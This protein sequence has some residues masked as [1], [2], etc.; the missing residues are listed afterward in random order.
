MINPHKKYQIRSLSKDIFQGM[1]TYE[2]SL[3]LEIAAE[4]AVRAAKTILRVLDEQ[5]GPELEDAPNSSYNDDD[6][7]N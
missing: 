2:P 1:I 3:D 7:D 4:K 6:N 5:L